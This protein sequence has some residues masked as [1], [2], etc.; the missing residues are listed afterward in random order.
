M[1]KIKKNL[2]AKEL[3]LLTVVCFIVAYI[4]PGIIG[5]AISL[6]G[7][8]LLAMTIISFFRNLASKGKE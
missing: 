3:F 7:A 4:V 1:K 2:S 6:L 8:I 5:S